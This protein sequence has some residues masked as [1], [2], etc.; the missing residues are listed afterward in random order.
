M[1]LGSEH[2]NT[3]NE[4]RRKPSTG[5]KRKMNTLTDSN[6]FY[7]E[8]SMLHMN[9][10][11]CATPFTFTLRA[12]LSVVTVHAFCEDLGLALKAAVVA[13]LVKLGILPLTSFILALTAAV[14]PKLVILDISTST[15]LF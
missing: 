7:S 10:C 13:K 12:R 8:K 5:K 1:H 9:F 6:Y 2:A 14:V 11:A 3:M 15:H 4:R